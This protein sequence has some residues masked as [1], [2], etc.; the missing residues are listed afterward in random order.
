MNGANMSVKPAQRPERGFAKTRRRT[1]AYRPAATRAAG[2][3]TPPLAA[4]LHAAAAHAQA[5][6]AQP[7]ALPLAYVFDSAGPAAR[8][9]LILGWA[10]LALCTSV[11]VVIAVL[12]ALALFRRRA[13]TAGLTE[14]GGLGFVYAGTAISTALL[15]AALVYMLWVLA[16]VAKPPRPPAVTIA[17]TAYDWWWK[18]DYGGGPPDGFTTANELHVPVGEPVLI[19]LRSA[20]VIHAFWA[21]QLASKTQAIPGQINRQWMQ[22][23]RPGVYRGQC[24]QFCGAQHAQMGF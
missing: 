11:C 13:G 17:V 15:L 3:A 23:D 21:P 19:E 24:T 12:L 20:D 8:P 7:A 18:A 14:R 10:L 4:A 5:H 1:A 16:A 6:A 2:A 22:A 9:V